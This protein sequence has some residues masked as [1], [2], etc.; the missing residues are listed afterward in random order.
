MHSHTI[1]AAVLLTLSAASHA[2]DGDFSAGFQMQGRQRVPISSPLGAGQTAFLAQQ[3]NG[4]IV[5]A[6][7]SD[8]GIGGN[9]DFFI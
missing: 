2:H 9:P 6:T 4:Q 3:S 1:K 5:L 7:S 8:A